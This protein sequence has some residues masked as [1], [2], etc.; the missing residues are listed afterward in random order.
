M[1]T[2]YKDG[3]ALGVTVSFGQIGLPIPQGNGFQD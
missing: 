2:D 3:K 1:H